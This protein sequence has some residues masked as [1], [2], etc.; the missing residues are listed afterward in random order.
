[1]RDAGRRRSGRPA[2]APARSGSGAGLS[3][4]A[5]LT[6][7]LVAAAVLPL[8]GFGI[9]LSRPAWRGRATDSTLVRVS[10]WRIAA[11]RRRRPAR[12]PARDRPRRARCAPIAHAVDRVAGGRPA[13]PL[14]LAGDDEFGPARREPQPPGGATSSDGTGSWA[15]SSS[16]SARRPR[17]TGRTARRARDEE[18]PTAFGMIDARI[19]SSTRPVP[20]RRIIPG[21]SRPI[22]AALRA[23]GRTAR[24]PRRPPAC[25]APLGRADQDLVELYAIEVAVAIR[26]IQLYDQVEDQNLRLIELDE[27]KDDFLRGVAT[28]CRPRSRA[29]AA[30][31]SSWG[32]SAPT[33]GSGSSPSRPTASPDRAP[34]ADVAP[35]VRRAPAA[36]EV[37][38][39]APRVRRAWDA[40]GVAGVPFELGDE[41]AGWLAIADPDQLDQVLWALLDNA[42]RYGGGAAIRAHVA[43]RPAEGRLAVTIADAG[44]GVR[45]DDRDRI[46][47]RYERGAAGA[48]AEGTGLGLY[49]SRS[50]CRR[51]AATSSSSHAAGGAAFTVLSRRASGHVPTVLLAHGRESPP[52]R[53][54]SS[55]GAVR[56][57]VAGSNQWQGDEK[58]RLRRL[59]VD[60]NH[61]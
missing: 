34:A 40:L 16:P 51:W 12:V 55:N 19:C 42:A 4:R 32:R 17:R 25:H 48:S 27:A 57:A 59:K 30:T 8:A 31:P 53:A 22:R 35:R 7:G 44:P 5:R 13:A 24:R 21:E 6:L 60:G 33:A 37:L 56:R 9:V 1:M 28:T 15:G 49:V 20:V 18:R 54:P 2:R 26:N 38:A 50:L 29:S 10:V 45:P 58:G 43:P 61:P 41:A 23:P 52:A 36:K 14:E 39:L 47:D 11:R 3:F 46:F